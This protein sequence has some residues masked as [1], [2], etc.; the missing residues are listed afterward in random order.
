[1]ISEVSV[2]GQLALLLLDPCQSRNIVEEGHGR[3]KLFISWQL[4]RKEE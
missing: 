2:H 3:R 1:M 4:E